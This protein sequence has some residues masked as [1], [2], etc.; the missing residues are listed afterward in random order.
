MVQ[1]SQS[2]PMQI[3]PSDRHTHILVTAARLFHEKGYVNT[4]MTEI[5]RKCGL[6]QSS[7][8]YWYGQKEDIL[9][10]LLALNR[11]ALTFAEARVAESGSPA[12]RLLR[13]LRF[14]IHE[15]C[16][17][18]LDISEVEVMAEQQPDI[19]AEFW[20]DTAALHRSLESLIRDGMAAG[21]FSECDPEVAALHICAAEEGVQHRYRTAGAHA[22]DGTSPFRYR[23]SSSRQVAYELAAML[24]RGLLRSPDQLSAITEAA[25]RYDDLAP[26]PA[27][28][29]PTLA[30]RMNSEK[31]RRV[32]SV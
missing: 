7:L 17:S 29:A 16:S 14:D 4:T 8:Y 23:S 21:E 18:P 22:P 9:V 3:A 15:L 31:A 5:A 19:F 20:A 30:A 11:V 10:G 13:L 2:A 1:R 24:M 25:D 27:T 12:V 28:A 6:A 26:V 32:A